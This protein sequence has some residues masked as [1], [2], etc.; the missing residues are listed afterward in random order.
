[1]HTRACFGYRGCVSVLVGSTRR[2]DQ[3]RQRDLAFDVTAHALFRRLV[4]LKAFKADIGAGT[5]GM[6]LPASALFRSD[7]G[8]GRHSDSLKT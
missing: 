3:F 5:V 8:L 7:L 2:V 4:R 6:L 1:M